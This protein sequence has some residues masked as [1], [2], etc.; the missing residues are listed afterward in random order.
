M[1]KQK[2]MKDKMYGVILAAGKGDRIKPLS[3]DLPKPLLPICN[4][5]IM[6]YQLQDMMRLGIKDYVFVVGHLKEKIIK[7]FGDG[8][9]WGV[10]IRYV[11]Q[12]EKLG[13]AH[14]VG[15]LENYVDAPFMLFLGDIFIVPK[16]LNRMVE[17]FQRKKAGAVLAVK[18]ERDCESIKRNFT[19]SLYP[20][21]NRVKRVIEKPRF[22]LTDLKGCG[23][24]LFDQAIFD[25]IRCTPRTAMRDEYEI[26]TAI[27]IL[28]ED[29]C[30]V[31]TSEV[32]EWDMNVTIPQDLL[33]CNRRQL[34][35]ICKDNVICKTAKIAP[36]A[37]IINSVIGKNVEIHH[38]I[39]I[40]D[41]VILDNVKIK[42]KNDF[43][44][45]LV[46]STSIIRLVS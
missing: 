44:N 24:Y 7:Y 34:K 3:F 35:Y 45:N 11:E 1:R 43:N 20:Q 9:S 13:I 4:K 22:L 17:A 19:V 16:N 14:A 21:T 28:I 5:P 32:V 29:G 2:N 46:S 27:Q 38:P 41:S 12:K 40:K 26:T 25:A 8:N 10:N 37:K 15:Q 33:L 30:S 36:N 23:I 42:E 31:Y 18:K 6:E 39:I